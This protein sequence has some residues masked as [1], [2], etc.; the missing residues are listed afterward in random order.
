MNIQL[1]NSIIEFHKEGYQVFP[2]S[3]V[4]KVPDGPWGKYHHEDY[5]NEDDEICEWLKKGYESF[6]LLTGKTNFNLEVM[7]FDKLK[8]GETIFELFQY[9]TGDLIKDCPIVKT[10]GGG[11]HLYYKRTGESKSTKLAYK[12]DQGKKEINDTYYAE[13]PE[14][15]R[16]KR[17]DYQIVCEIKGNGSYVILP[18][19]LHKSGRLYEPDREVRD[20]I[21]AIPTLSDEVV[22]Q[23]YSI[24]RTF[25][26]LKVKEI[27]QEEHEAGV[28]G[29][30]PEIKRNK[31][32]YEDKNSVINRYN[33]DVNIDEILEKFGYTYHS[34]RNESTL[35]Y[36]R[37]GSNK[38]SV[39]VDLETNRSWH[40]S[41]SDLLYSGDDDMHQTPF[42]VFKMFL[43]DNNLKAAVKD[44]KIRYGLIKERKREPVIRQWGNENSQVSA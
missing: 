42:N 35:H 11:Y 9:V 16:H 20:F 18:K 3:S 7:D 12:F 27:T 5:K 33:V 19:S 17:K 43:H 25:D 28:V 37:P 13:N 36:C 30:K 6:A 24:A 38:Y 8:N 4:S 21:S 1:K 39:I 10:G 29:N 34:N 32:Y 14:E 23:L 31:R 22:E 15:K 41:D 40:F 2:I 44:A 26:E